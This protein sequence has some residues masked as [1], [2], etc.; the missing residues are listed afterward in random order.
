MWDSDMF[1]DSEDQ[2]VQK[3]RKNFFKFVKDVELH[4]LCKELSL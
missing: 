3:L 2:W 1:S 4:Y